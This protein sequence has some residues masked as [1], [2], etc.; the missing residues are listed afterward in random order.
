M[1]RHNTDVLTQ[2]ARQLKMHAPNAKQCHL[3]HGGN[4][5]DRTIVSITRA[6]R[7]PQIQVKR[8]EEAPSH[9]EREEVEVP[10]G[11]A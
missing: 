5:L 6:M 9:A 3:E 7:H 8:D 1:K 4:P 11:R 10:A 2:V